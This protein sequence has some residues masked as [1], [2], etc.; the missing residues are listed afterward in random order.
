M[1]AEDLV[2][3]SMARYGVGTATPA[4]CEAEKSNVMAMRGSIKSWQQLENLPTGSPD[5]PSDSV[6]EKSSSGLCYVADLMWFVI[7]HVLV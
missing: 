1:H 6:K 5:G 4:L 3:F 7:E 2:A